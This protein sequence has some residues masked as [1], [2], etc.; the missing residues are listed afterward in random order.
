MKRSRSF[1]IVTA[2]MLMASSTLAGVTQAAGP[3]GS[4]LAAPSAAEGSPGSERDIDDL[5]PAEAEGQALIA[6]PKFHTGGGIATYLI[7]LT[8]APVPAYRGGRAGLPST[9]PRSGQ[10]LDPEAPAAQ[11]YVDFLEE[12]QAEFITQLERSAGRD[13]DV[14]F[15][16]QYAV[17]GL[18]V[19]LTADEAR[20]ISTNP[21]VLSIAPDQIRELQTDVGPEQINADEVWNAATDLG[22][23]A[24]YLGEGIVIGTIDSGISP[25]NESFADVGDDGYDH[26]NPLGA[27][28]YLGVCDSTP[29]NPVF[30]PDFP[31]NDKLIGAWVF[32][33]LNETAIDNDGHGSHTA[34]TSGGNVVTGVTVDGA[35]GTFDISGV[36]PHANVISYLGCCSV[37]G[38]T[39]S[40]DQAIEDQVD[41]INYSIGSSAPSD[42]WNDFDAIGFLN[43]RA[44]GIFV[45]TSNGNDGPGVATTGSPADA[46]WITSVGASTHTRRN[47]NVLTDLTS[48]S[49]TLPDISGTGVT[50]A[51]PVSTP[52]V[53]AAEFGDEFCEDA[54]GNETA[55]TGA[56]VICTRGVNGR[57]EKSQNVADQGAVG[58]VLVNDLL[59]NLSLLGD[60]Y[61][62]PGVFISNTDGVTLRDWLAVGAD[63]AAAIQGTVFEYGPEFADIMSSFSSRG[64]NR[65]VDTIV[66]SVSAPGVDVLA[67]L[68]DLE[69]PTG[70]DVHAFLSGTSMASPHVAGAGALMTQIRPEWSPAEMQS[71]L[72]TSA[73]TGVLSHDLSPGTPFDQGSGRVDVAAAVSVGL[74]FDETFE[75]YDAS[76]PA[77]GGDPKTL[78]LASFA[79]SQCLVQCTW[80]RTATV[81]DNAIGAGPIADG[82]TWD[83]TWS[84]DAGL[85]LG[86]VLSP[87]TVSPGDTMSIT[88][89]A[90]VAG[91]DVGTTYFGRITLTPSDASIPTVTMPVAVV[92]SSGVLPDSIDIETRRDAGS[93]VVSGVESI[94]VVDFQ[95]SV[96]GLVEGAQ[97]TESLL[98]DP[99]NDDPYDVLTDV[100]VTTIDV[101]AGA[102]SL[103]V[104]T[105]AAEMPDADLFV[106]SGTT[107]SLATEEC[108]STTGSA[109]EY[110]AIDDPAA[111]PWW[112]VVQNWDGTDDQPDSF[113]L[114][115]G[116]VEGD[117]G[118][119]TIVGP[120]P[121]PTG[122]PYDMTVTWDLPDAEAGDVFYGEAVLGSDV[123]STD[124]IGTLPIR[125]VRIE[126]DVTKDASVATAAA[127]DEIEYTVTVQPNVTDT[128]LE[129]TLSDLVPEGLTLVDG[130]VESSDGTAVVDGNQIDWNVTMPTAAGAAGD[131]VISTPADSEDCLNWAGFVD[132]GDPDGANIP[133]STVIDGDSVAATAFSSIG[134]FPF[135]G[136]SYPNLVVAEDGFAT[137]TGGYGGAVFEPQVLPDAALPNGVIAPL[138]SDLIADATAGRGVR[139][140]NTGTAAVIQW[141]NLPEWLPGDDATGP[142]V[143]T[144]QAWIYNSVS[145]DR[146][147]MTFEYASLEAL[148]A[149]STI[150]VENLAGTQATSYLDAAAATG[151]VDGDT[152]CYDYVGP[153][154]AEATLTY[155]VTV[156]DPPTA[157]VLT[158]E[159]SHIT[160]DPFAQSAIATADVTIGEVGQA[161]VTVAPGSV[162]FGNTLV[163]STS[164]PRVVTITNSGDLDVD[165]TDIAVTGPF[166]ADGDDACDA[167][168]PAGESCT[169]SVTFSPTVVGAATGTL[170]ITSNAPLV[171]VALTGTG[172]D[173]PVVD[174]PEVIAP[175]EP[176]RYWD[177]RPSP[178]L[179]G[180]QSD[181]G[182]LGAGATYA[183]QIAGRG[184]VPIDAVGVVANLT[185]I[186]PSAG[187]FATMYPCTDAVPTTSNVNFVVGSNVANNS[188]VPLSD[189]GQVCVYT[190]SESH[191][192]LDVNGFVPEGAGLVGVAPVRLLDTR[193][194]NPTVDGVAQGGGPVAAGQFIEVQVAGRGN[195]PAD[196]ATAVVNVTAVRP[197]GVG[198]VTLYPCGVRPLA[199]TLNYAAGQIVPNG[200]VTDL[201][202]DGTVCIYTEEASHLLLDVT[203]YVPTG[204]SGLASATPARLLDTRAFGVTVDGES[205]ADGPIPGDTFIEVQVAGRAGVP[206]DATAA[207]LNVAAIRPV[208]PG[209]VT[210]YPCGV[211]P[212]TSN[213]NHGTG[214]IVANN[215]FTKLSASG[216]VCIYVSSET[217]AILDVSGWVR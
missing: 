145:P 116:V 92:P 84:T 35:P 43:A 128:D 205:M 22:L 72:M 65:A 78:N 13:V 160:D 129:Y 210:L 135:Y 181:T 25:F 167:T 76:N 45:A 122:E 149:I 59:N 126:D 175:L 176:G 67:A 137:V 6:A 2:T 131:Y 108:A 157:G 111:G 124:D 103:V 159:V 62:I 23:P 70:G 58:F 208:A 10:Q 30:D 154:F 50:A 146:P 198:Y 139:L 46:P 153:T 105:I 81:P 88:V 15:T 96:N 113:T 107:P 29:G 90:D 195:V 194:G 162:A 177:T 127:G 151:L 211:R 40:I 7:R 98:E 28:N 34:G 117:L 86:V 212:T 217:E 41:V 130:S 118:N 48:S 155:T 171:S 101:P 173:E 60:Q 140:A 170:T 213:L 209:F 100:Y 169:V 189:D 54:T 8:E 53:D 33:D 196:A 133:V 121:T 104:E 83:A 136:E 56:I 87:A 164:A 51:L 207:L 132:L 202:P 112:V 199:S 32:D 73:F 79:N 184:D 143:G 18:A 152:L 89:D 75:N 63:H 17:N 147:E 21:N 69:D 42:L 168:I 99:T 109:I 163:D 39:A 9:A 201:S 11:R 123:G 93:Q 203:G 20:E 74:L 55:F 5:V 192:A 110:C 66:P 142:S 191:F 200:A 216:T 144:F 68:T 102:N 174:D 185:V 197:S 161:E 114:S 71:A 85:D 134:P 158:N 166:A 16:Y 47:G 14:K 178:T 3:A 80:E 204:V 119:A 182:R 156:D 138:W 38:L 150:G 26:D 187:G 82:V 37:G 95:G 91:A 165:I 61:V 193:E 215:T 77:E 1:I 52:L 27:G 4:A 57:V 24:D 31:C 106:G 188:I 141:E 214:G 97:V 183:V 120:A 179:D 12:A 115:Y 36:A 44:A 94:E 190:T 148:P 64:P 206:A 172:T 180:Q 19:E 125:L 186:A 49:G